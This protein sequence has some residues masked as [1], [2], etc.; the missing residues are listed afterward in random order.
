MKTKR[1]TSPSAD[2]L[3]EFCDE[4][5]MGTIESIEYLDGLLIMAREDQVVGIKAAR[6]RFTDM[7]FQFERHIGINGSKTAPEGI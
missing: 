4:H 1:Y 3:I 5:N 6:N 7:L 2:D